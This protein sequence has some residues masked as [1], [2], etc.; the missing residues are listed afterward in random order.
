M[1]PKSV[2]VSTHLLT[3]TLF[4]CYEGV[5]VTKDICSAHFPLKVCVK[6]MPTAGSMHTTFWRGIFTADYS[7][8]LQPI[9]KLPSVLTKIKVERAH[10]LFMFRCCLGSVTGVKATETGYEVS[11]PTF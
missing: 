8:L 1:L 5:I 4:P 2:T 10:F 3:V 6:L 11:Q 9:M 7:L